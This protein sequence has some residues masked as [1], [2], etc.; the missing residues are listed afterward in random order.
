M[1]QNFRQPKAAKF[2]QA[3]S[4]KVD[5]NERLRPLRDQIVVKLVDVDRHNGLIVVHNGRKCIR[6]VLVAAGPGRR[7]IRRYRNERGEVNAIGELPGLVP[8]ELQVGDEIELSPARYTE[9][10][11]GGEPHLLAKE[12]DVLGVL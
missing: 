5:A 11:I 8:M 10:T 4:A 12:G 2:K 6:G 1:Q 7:P 9:I 3:K